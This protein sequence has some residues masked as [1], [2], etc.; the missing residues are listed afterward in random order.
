MAEAN[1]KGPQIKRRER[2]VKLP[3]E[4]EGFEFQVWVNAPA[5]FWTTAVSPDT[6]EPERVEA[7]SKIVIAHNGWLDF[8]GEPFPQPNEAGF[9]EAIPTELAAC[10]IA[11]VQNEMTRLPNSLAPQKRR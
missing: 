9:W 7:L 4:Y 1:G 8:D 5:K 6:E 2:W 3:E 10:V 11:S